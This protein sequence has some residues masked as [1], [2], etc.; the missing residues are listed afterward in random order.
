MSSPFEI[1]RV[2]PDADEE[3]IKEAY[4]ERMK[5]THPDQGGSARA[6]QA[7]REAY[8]QAMSGER[9][10]SDGEAHHGD[11]DAGDDA[12]GRD[13]RSM[14]PEVEYLNYEVLDDYGWGLEDP[15]LF[16]KAAD[17]DLGTVDYGS[18]RVEPGDTLLE[19]AE[20]EGYAWPY[21]CRGGACANCAVVVRKGE[22]STPIDHILPDEMVEEGIQLS[23][24]AVPL[25]DHLQVLYN[26][27]HMPELEDLLLPPKPFEQAHADD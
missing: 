10:A 19:A 5:E 7:V 21:A 14:H 4:R 16:E 13:S 17:A 8:E 18:F 24:N 11:G 22:L 6:F 1:L 15:D 2:D 3:E 23:C 27:K 25:S 20:H 12:S 9:P 26:V